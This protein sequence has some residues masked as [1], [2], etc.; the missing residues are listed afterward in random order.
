M[1]TPGGNARPISTGSTSGMYGLQ[2]ARDGDVWIAS[3][4]A[5][6]LLRHSP[7]KQA[8]TFYQLATPGSI[9]FELAFD[10]TG[11]LWFTAAG[12]PNYVGALSLS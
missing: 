2:V 1:S 11:D 5:N 6:S 10:G 8:C 4:G 9:P 12:N 7:R 3:A